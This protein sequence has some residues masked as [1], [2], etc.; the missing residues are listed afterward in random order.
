MTA[1]SMQKGRKEKG[2]FLVA[3]AEKGATCIVNAQTRPTMICLPV[4]TLKIR[5]GSENEN[6]SG[7]EGNVKEEEGMGKA[8]C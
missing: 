2:A 4:M 3:N 7:T 5:M 1:S 8:G 6:E